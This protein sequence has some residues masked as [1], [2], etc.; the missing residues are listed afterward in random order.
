[1]IARVTNSTIYFQLELILTSDNSVLKE[2]R[3]CRGG[4][5]D[6]THDHEDIR[7][8]HAIRSSIHPKATVWSCTMYIESHTRDIRDRQRVVEEAIDDHVV[9][10][11][12]SKIM[13][14]M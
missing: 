11:G 8:D 10:L 4:P 13:V 2:R 1:M 14:Y 3:K 12:L 9:D 5:Y 6:N 7:I